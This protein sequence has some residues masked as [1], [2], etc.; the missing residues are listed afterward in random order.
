[1]GD[2]SAQLVGDVDAPELLRATLVESHCVHQ[3]PAGSE[4]PE[5]VRGIGDPYRHLA[6][7]AHCGA[8][9]DTGRTL[10]GGRVDA[11]VHDP[12]GGVM[13]WSELDVTR[14]MGATH[15]VE[16]QARSASEGRILE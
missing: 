1:M 2:E 5:E 16:H 13:V 7:V 8:R 12:P 10:D 11:T 6:D 4:R 9:P 14:D 3:D 15:V